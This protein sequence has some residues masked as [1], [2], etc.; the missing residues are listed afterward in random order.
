MN[1]LP[2]KEIPD[3]ILKDS[4]LAHIAA[5]YFSVG[6]MERQN[7]VLGDTRLYPVDIAPGRERG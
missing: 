4:V 1:I 5:A 7:P 3:D 6:R 2:R